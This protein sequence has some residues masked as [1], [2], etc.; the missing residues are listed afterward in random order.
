MASN[1]RTIGIDN[2]SKN[3]ELYG[4]KKKKKKKKKR[5]NAINHS[6]LI[7]SHKTIQKEMIHG[8]T[9]FVL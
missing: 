6:L 2:G 1:G 4:K 9:L 5:T 7:E 3:E 8:A